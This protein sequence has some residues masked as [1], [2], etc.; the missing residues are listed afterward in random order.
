VNSLQRDKRLKHLR[1]Q[2]LK[3]KGWRYLRYAHLRAFVAESVDSV[4][5]IGVIGAGLGFS[6]LA[7]AIEFPEVDFTLTDIVIAGRPNYW[8]CMDLCM[9]CGIKNVRFGVWDLLESPPCQFDA[10]VSTEVLEHIPQADL[11]LR[12]T[13]SAARKAVYALTPFATE[14][15]NNDPVRRSRAMHEHEH[16]VCGYDASY[17]QVVDPEA[18]IFGTYWADGGLILRNALA[19][20][21]AE[22]IETKYDDLTSAAENDLR[23]FSPSWQKCLGIKAIMRF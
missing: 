12:N 7:I 21:S 6:E 16:V 22:E 8:R 14:I 13:R 17:F 4:R 2:M 9:R 3:Q 11:A 18:R 23:Q 5:T 1:L 10:V 20:L 15:E 19:A